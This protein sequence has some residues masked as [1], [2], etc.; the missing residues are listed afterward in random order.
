MIE[1]N[2]L[3]IVL[4]EERH[5]ESLRLMRNDPTTWHWL[6]KIDPISQRE[7]KEWFEELQDDKS[8]M[9]LAIETK[10]KK[11]GEFGGV[12]GLE[13]LAKSV[14][15]GVLRSDEWDRTNRSVRIGIDVA[16]KHRG[17]GYATEA[18]TAFVDYLFKQ[19][20]INRLWLL[21][22]EDNEIAVKLYQKIGFK[23]EGRQREAIFRD[24]K[25]QNYLSM[26]LLEKE[27]TKT[28]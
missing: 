17:R 4:L 11:L 5:L 16:N 22:C 12:E 21:V 20:N 24:G 9:Y 26:S 6:T 18:L 25:Y 13:E 23:E 14:F 8:R 7:Q 2:R 27:W 10:E 1:T 28:K 15:V 3:K 19:Q